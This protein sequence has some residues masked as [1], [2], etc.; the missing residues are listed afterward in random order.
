MN[1]MSTP[2]LPPT[3]R[4][5]NGFITSEQW[6]SHFQGLVYVESLNRA[7]CPD[8]CILPKRT[9]TV[10]YGGYRFDMG[11]PGLNTRD[12]WKAWLQHEVYAP[13]IVSDVYQD[14]AL[15]RGVIITRDGRRLVNI[16]V[17]R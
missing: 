13:T 11:S 3:T 12:P 17:T 8:D 5:G 15:P 6:P 4:Q 7:F 9:F 10:R 2:N 16:G 1:E 14:A